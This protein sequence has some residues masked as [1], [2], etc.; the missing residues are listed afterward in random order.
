[1]E[2]DPRFRYRRAA[3]GRS[4]IS[5]SG[6]SDTRRVQTLPRLPTSRVR[7]SRRSSA[8]DTTAGTPRRRRHLRLLLDLTP[9]WGRTTPLL[10]RLADTVYTYQPTG[11]WQSARGS[12]GAGGV[13]VVSIASDDS[14]RRS[15]VVR[16]RRHDGDRGHRTATFDHVGELAPSIEDGGHIY[17]RDKRLAQNDRMTDLVGLERGSAMAG[18]RSPATVWRSIPSGGSS[19]VPRTGVDEVELFGLPPVEAIPV[20]G[21][22]RRPRRPRVGAGHDRGRHDGRLAAWGGATS[23]TG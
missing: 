2:H 1:V 11:Y 22:G 23:P 16:S 21:A 19:A 8:S 3:S 17:H 6:V 5:S 20:G 10:S 7:Y 12:T 9:S 15:A 13:D 14:P 4:S 18:D